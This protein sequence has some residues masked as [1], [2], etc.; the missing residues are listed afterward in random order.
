MRRNLSDGYCSES[1]H[2]P[3]MCPQERRQ[4]QIPSEDVT[5]AVKVTTTAVRPLVVTFRSNCR[6]RHLVVETPC[7]CQ[8]HPGRSS[9]DENSCDIDRQSPEDI[10]SLY[11]QFPKQSCCLSKRHHC[12]LIESN[13]PPPPPP[14]DVVAS[15][16]SS[17][18]RKRR[19]TS[20][21][22]DDK[23][24]R[25]RKWQTVESNKFDTQETPNSYSHTMYKKQE[26]FHL[27][28]QKP[29]SWY[30]LKST[31]RII[32]SRSCPGFLKECG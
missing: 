23:G 20:S 28:L 4:I 32:R 26:T 31:K 18:K 10:E 16:V 2:S 6:R 5:T 9:I 15:G 13:S 17:G 14:P 21:A 24:N 12:C 27:K 22:D 11:R 25:A 8:Q 19:Y 3:K 7:N 30:S 29:N 1:L